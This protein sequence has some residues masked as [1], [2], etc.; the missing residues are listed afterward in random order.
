MLTIPLYSVVAP[1]G[2]PVINSLCAATVVDQGINC[3][4]NVSSCPTG[5]TLAKDFFRTASIRNFSVTSVE[6]SFQNTYPD[7]LRTLCINNNFRTII[8]I[9]IGHS[10]FN[11]NSSYYTNYID[12]PTTS[13][14]DNAVRIAK[15]CP[16]GWTP[17]QAKYTLSTLGIGMTGWTAPWGCCP[18][19]YKFIN[20]KSH[21]NQT[22]Y[23][24]GICARSTISGQ[25]PDY[26]DTRSDGTA[27]G[28]YASDDTLL[29]AIPASGG[30]INPED[31]NVMFSSWQAM[32]DAIAADTDYIYSYYSPEVGGAV[33]A[34]LGMGFGTFFNDL[35]L[36]S[37][38]PRVR[39]G[40]PA[41][42]ASRIC[43]ANTAC[44]ITGITADMSTVVDAQSFEAAGASSQC[45]RCYTAG[46]T[47]G[48]STPPDMVPTS[49]SE[50]DTSIGFV[51]YCNADGTVRD[52]TL[53]GTPDITRGYL[54][55]DETNQALYKQCF[56]TG[57]I[58]TAIGCVD[59]TPTGIITGLIRI[60]LGIM[61][62]VALLQMIYVGI[63]YQQGNTEKIKGARTQLIATITGIAV[64]VFSVL[65]LRIIGVNILDTVSNG[66]V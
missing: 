1:A 60:A 7:G 17:Q 23:Q 24:Q 6:N 49:S 34:Q 21:A 25:I 26:L 48:T 63:L 53:L 37:G 27:A 14:T 50:V 3:I 8:P 15:F 11:S 18:S 46:D 56:D 41:P 4:D 20:S 61:G 55:E 42:G 62:G 9:Y 52:E 32:Q 40:I 54:L 64:L 2:S 12:G 19:G 28:I 39:T 45:F 43:P 51:R 47:I 22:G 65:I 38:S 58:Y 33:Q 29:R 66:T 16:A 35:N 10:E 30:S 57:G 13:W 36:E 59:P 31:P 5:Y 44:A